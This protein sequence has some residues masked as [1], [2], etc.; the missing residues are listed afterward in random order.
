[1]RAD[2][3]P[4]MRHLR[5]LVSRIGLWWKEPPP[6]WPFDPHAGQPVP[7]KPRPHARSGAVALEEP[8]E[9]DRGR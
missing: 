1:M 9:D 2:F 7:R 4:L 5:Q 8:H 3:E 6:G